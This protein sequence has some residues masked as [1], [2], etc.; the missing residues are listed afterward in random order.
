MLEALEQDGIFVGDTTLE[1][2][3]A[4][5]FPSAFKAAGDEIFSTA[6]AAKMRDEIDRLC[7]TDDFQIRKEIVRRIESRGKGRFAQ[8]LAS[9]LVR[10]L[11]YPTS[12]EAL[13]NSVL[14]ALDYASV[15][16]RGHPLN[17]GDDDSERVGAEARA[18]RP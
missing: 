6:I 16:C 1:T 14:R 11:T 7:A 15:V 10:E 13:G 8:R 9:H 12:E 5:V 3:L 17:D 2:D 18:A 4:R